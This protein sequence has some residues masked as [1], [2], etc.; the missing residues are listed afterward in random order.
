MGAKVKLN[1]PT[2]LREQCID[3]QGTALGQSVFRILAAAI[4]LQHADEPVTR[5]FVPT[6]D[7]RKLPQGSVRANCLEPGRRVP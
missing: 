6:L 2:L 4:G 7:Q 3:G 5:L 1:D